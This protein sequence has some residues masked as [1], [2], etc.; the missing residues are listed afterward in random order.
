MRLAAWGR[1]EEDRVLL[2]PRHFDQR[3]TG[4]SGV[5]QVW[6]KSPT[7]R[8][9]SVTSSSGPSIELSTIWA[10]SRP[11]RKVR[12]AGALRVSFAFI[13]QP[14][15]TG[16]RGLQAKERRPSPRSPPQGDPC[17]AERNGARRRT[18]RRSRSQQSM[19]RS[20]TRG[21]RD[22]A[23]LSEFLWMLSQQGNVADE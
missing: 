17:S 14:A 9:R 4:A 23:P 6:R 1:R 11:S 16:S 19:I 5:F 12:N 2:G 15:S 3:A 18:L 21:I 10:R 13:D 20:S 8:A 7:L 22:A